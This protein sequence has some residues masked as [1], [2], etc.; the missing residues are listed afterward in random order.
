MS[1]HLASASARSDSTFIQAS[2]SALLEP[3]SVAF[4]GASDRAETLGR[5]MVDMARVGGYRGAVYAINPKYNRIGDVSCFPSISELPEKVD[6]IVLGVG[7]E[8]LEATLD[9]AITHGARAATIF[10]SCGLPGDDGALRERITAK[11]HSAGMS[12]CGGNCMG[13]YNNEIGLRVA[14][15]PAMQAMVAGG[16]G[17]LAQSGSVFGALAHN[18]PRLKFGIVISSGAE[19]VTTSADY[20]RWMVLSN[21]IRVIGMFLE[22]VRDPVGF[23]S[24][25]ELATSRDIPVVILKVGRTAASAEMALSHTGALVGNDVAYGAL[26]KRYG[27]IQVDDEDELAATLCFFQQPRR[28]GRGGLVAIHDSGGERELAV[29]IAD[30]VGVTYPRLSERTKEKLADIIDPELVPGNPLDAWGG[31]REF[32]SVFSEAFAALMDDDAAAVGVMFCNIRDGYYVS[33]GY[34]E[35]AI[36]THQKTQKPVAVASNYSMVRHDGLVSRL[37]EAGIPVID[38][39]RVALK[40]VKH[41]LTW[42]DR[43]KARDLK[44]PAASG[45]KT[46]V[47]SWKERLALGVPM[48]EG[49][50]LSLLAEYGIGTANRALVSGQAEL[51]E[52]G[53]RMRYPVVLKTATPGILHKSDVDGVVLGISG[54]VE[55]ERAYGDMQRRLGP[56]AIVAE[57]A[58][59]G[60]ELALG[61]VVDPQWGPIVFVSAGGVLIELLAD[62]AAAL[63]PVTHSEAAD[64][65]ASLKISK[66]LDGYRGAA[67]ADREGVIDALV[68]LSWLAWDFAGLISEV[69]VNPVIVNADGCTAVDALVVPHPLNRTSG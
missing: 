29:D 68:R 7:N 17:L 24:A 35:A 28:A 42:R 13:F 37:T 23:A 57:M 30:K 51:V 20:L 47:R 11:A 49:H 21:G 40:A 61:T 38:G 54:A 4:V 12:I 65:I 67:S 58:S 43:H 10:A 32:T 44:R 27:V 33:N 2:M 1:S 39:T 66:L 25:L 5:A 8:R 50:S 53:L 15:Y 18:D 36:A 31:A 26:F 69:D 41:L 55:L 48:S 56:A 45:G 59:K 3:R 63:A 22:T 52:A 19:M 60:I 6:H 14:G 16:I 9:D 34:V 46:V 64:M 62:K